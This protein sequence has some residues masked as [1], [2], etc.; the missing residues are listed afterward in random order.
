MIGSTAFNRIAATGA[1]IALI[2]ASAVFI[3]PTEETDGA[4]NLGFF[5]NTGM[6]GGSEEQYY[7]G[8]NIVNSGLLNKNKSTT[9]YVLS[10]SSI[11]ISAYSSENKIA[12]VNGSPPSAG[13]PSTIEWRSMYVKGTL[14][15]GD[16]I[17]VALYLQNHA[18][19]TYLTFV[20]VDD[21]NANAWPS[22]FNNLGNWDFISSSG[23]S[24][25]LYTKMSFDVVKIGGYGYGSNQS[26]DVY[27]AAGSTI[28]LG[29]TDIVP[30]VDSSTSPQI[31]TDYGTAYG[32]LSEPGEYTITITDVGAKVYLN[33]HVVEVLKSVTVEFD[34]NGGSPI[35]SQIIESGDCALSPEDPSLYGYIFKGWFTDDGT[36]LNEWDFADPVTEDMTLYAKWEGNLEFTTD[37]VADGKVTAVDGSP[38]TVSFVATN[39]QNYT[40]VLWDFGDGTSST[41][42]YETPYNGQPGTYTATLTVFNNYGSD[43]TEFIIEVPEMAAGG[44]GQ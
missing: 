38:G 9:V 15:S 11:F 24:A 42:I 5:T 17:Q 26:F 6:D 36:F 29:C 27:M 37:P 22:S 18:W 40:S 21:P 2:L 25:N 8:V 23:D 20:A 30:F 3:L 35:T 4:T 43:T 1:I 31:S 39:S 16:A 41:N 14:E 44:G 13:V 7:L 10:G 33:L 32:V 28:N 19:E 12:Y 34:S